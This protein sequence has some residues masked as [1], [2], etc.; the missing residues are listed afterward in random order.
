LKYSDSNFKDEIYKRF[1][2][3]F[4]DVKPYYTSLGKTGLFL[5]AHTISDSQKLIEQYGYSTTIHFVNLDFMYAN[6]YDGWFL[7]SKTGRLGGW[8]GKS[9]I[10]Q[11]RR[12]YSNAPLFYWKKI[13]DEKLRKEWEE[14]IEELTIKDETIAKENPYAYLPGLVNRMRYKSLIKLKD[15]LEKQGLSGNEL[16]IA[17]ISEFET[18]TINASIVGHEGRHTIDKKYRFIFEPFCKDFEYRAKL[19]EI[20]FSNDPFFSFAYSPVYLRN[21][22]SKSKHSQGSR[23]IVINLVNWMNQNKNDIKGFNTEKATLTQLDLLTE[24]QFLSAFKEMD[25]LNKK[26]G[27]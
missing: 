10:V 13:T 26:R 23:K 20:L 24:T 19:S 15:S 25:P 5:F 11:M 22:T 8:N 16:R 14:K 4:K 7:G 21:M 6:S 17:F 1:G 18:Y 12:A 3:I 9:L 27:N 2:T